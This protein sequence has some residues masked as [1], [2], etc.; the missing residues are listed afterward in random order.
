MKLTDKLD[1]LM[2][3]KGI[4]RAELSRGS[5]IPYTTIANFYEKGTDNV[6][7]STL[8]KLAEYF[9]CSL[10]YLVDDNIS[11]KEPIKPTTVAAHLP[12]GLEL[13]EEEQ[14]DLDEY[15]QFILSRRKK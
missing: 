13:T 14:E 7:L 2:D 9:D 4:N 12:D 1:L 5:G 10:D 8:K 6:K 3:E 11:E 15:I